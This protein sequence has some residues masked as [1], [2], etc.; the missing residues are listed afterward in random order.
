MPTESEISIVSVLFR[1][2]PSKVSFWFAR[3]ISLQQRNSKALTNA[4][5]ENLN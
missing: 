4:L 5:V 2:L 1:D 3:G